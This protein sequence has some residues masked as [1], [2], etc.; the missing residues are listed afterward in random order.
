ME[1]RLVGFVTYAQ[2]FEDVMLWRALHD[3]PGGFYIDVGAAD[4]EEDSVTRVFYDHG[5]HGVNIE[6]SPDHFAG[7][8]AARPR[9]INLSCLVG[10]EP[11]KMDLYNIPD[12]GLSTVDRDLADRQAA[13][14][15]PLE[16]IAVTVRTL[17]DICHEYAP[18]DIHFL[19][20]DVEGAEKDVLRG[21]D[22]IAFRPWIVVVEATRPMSQDENWQDWDP[23][24]IEADYHFVWFDGLN[25]FYLAAERADALR[26]AFRTPPNVFDGWIRPRGLQQMAILERARAVQ[27]AAER[28]REETARIRS[29]LD[30]EARASRVEASAARTEASTLHAEAATLRTELATAQQEAS[31]AHAQAAILG[32]ELATAQQEASH[33]RTT[34]S[35]M[36]QSDAQIAALLASTS[37]RITAPLRGVSNLFGAQPMRRR[38]LRLVAAVGQEPGGIKGPARV[39][40]YGLG[41]AAARVPGGRAAARLA[42]SILPGPYRWLYARYS[43]YRNIAANA[44]TSDQ[45]PPSE[46]PLVT[47]LP[48]SPV[49]GYFLAAE[50]RAMLLRLRTGKRWMSAV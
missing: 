40:V 10:A 38:R 21:A 45:T 35:A 7:L 26:H 46:K 1:N 25:R 43:V 13:D 19:K 32:T 23:L 2:N 42:V 49:A 37:W 16:A 12:T 24:L 39:A 44:T 22:F 31:R 14:G 15:R 30:A 5:W 3:V 47:P 28:L 48:E 34:L 17:A 27:D 36:Q 6:P 4:P 29:A 33:L 9:D 18:S 11:G 41:R 8:A 20:I 50:E